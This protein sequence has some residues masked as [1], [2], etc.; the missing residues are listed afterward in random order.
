MKTKEEPKATP[1]APSPEAPV[2]NQSAT[3]Q[4]GEDPANIP[5]KMEKRNSIHLFFKN[6]VG[7]T[8][9]FCSSCSNCIRTYVYH[10]GVRFMIVIVEHAAFCCSVAVETLFHHC[11]SKHPLDGNNVS[12]IAAVWPCSWSTGQVDLYQKNMLI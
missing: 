8:S 5:R 6:L 12:N 3:S 11:F 1:K 10:V 9:T 4:S 2:D 7:Q